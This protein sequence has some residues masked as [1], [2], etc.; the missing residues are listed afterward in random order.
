[1]NQEKIY[2]IPHKN[3]NMVQDDGFFSNDDTYSEI[4]EKITKNIHIFLQ[5][6][7]TLEPLNAISIGDPIKCIAAF[8]V[9]PNHANT[10]SN[11]KDFNDLINTYLVPDFETFDTQ[12]SVIQNRT[13][14]GYEIPSPSNIMTLPTLKKVDV[15][16][17]EIT[18]TDIFN[19]L[20]TH[21]QI[22]CLPNQ[23]TASSF[24][25]PLR[26]IEDTYSIHK[27]YINT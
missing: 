16:K 22:I 1:M 24:S 8:I 25:L 15:Q 23:E 12:E 9:Y 14:I 11:P 26:K 19:G 27:K 17:K 7:I 4:L 21:Y 20:E 18:S 10:I 5:Q 2:K 13:I 3:L 6:Q